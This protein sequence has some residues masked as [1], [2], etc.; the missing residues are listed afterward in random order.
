M[1]DLHWVYTNKMKFKKSKVG[2]MKNSVKDMTDWWHKHNNSDREDIY[3]SIY[4][5]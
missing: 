5:E 4:S 2:G 3:V 1:E